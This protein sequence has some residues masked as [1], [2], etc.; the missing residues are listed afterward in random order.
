MV[1]REG[2]QHL[3]FDGVPPDHP[4]RTRAFS[5]APSLPPQEAR[6]L[7]GA[8]VFGKLNTTAALPGA[9]AAVSAFAPDLVLHEAAELAVRL[10]AE[11]AG[12]PAVSVSPSLS[13]REF[14]LAMASGVADLRESLGLA[15]DEEARSVL[16]GLTISWFPRSFDLPEAPAQV[17]RFRDGSSPA[18][19]PAAQRS[20]VYVTLGTEAAGLPF[21]AHVL[22][23]VV[24]GAARA[25]LP[26]VVASGKPVDLALLDG[27]E[28]DVRLQTWV[29]Q[30][31]VLRTARVVVCH[32]GSGTVVGA[33]ASQV[34][35]V[36]VPL[37]A[38][39]PDNA[40][41]IVET[42]CGLR[43]PPEAD[44]VAAATLEL[45]EHLPEGCVRMARELTALPPAEDAVPWLE[46]VAERGPGGARSWGSVAC[47]NPCE[48]L[49]HRAQTTQEPS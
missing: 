22:P 5:R 38:D 25:G 14:T 9:Q 3:P 44:Q 26:V 13:V 35:I 19:T 40:A 7:V 28:G 18:P 17:R 31:A 48:H 1:E 49:P 45:A 21:F 30:D 32:A 15:R 11:A 36:A 20:V 29:D 27:I 34:P 41:R 6:Q 10:A 4:E 12:V 33:L 23:E 16:E 42:G 24:R 46:A 2:L 43:V 37:F 47:S 8:V 39:Q